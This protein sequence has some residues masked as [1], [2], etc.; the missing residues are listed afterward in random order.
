MERVA[1]SRPYTHQQ[2]VEE[3]DGPRDQVT[4]RSVTNFSNSK[5][6]TKVG[7]VGGFLNMGFVTC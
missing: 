2:L 5:I 7:F 4:I 1:T 6:T 3:Q